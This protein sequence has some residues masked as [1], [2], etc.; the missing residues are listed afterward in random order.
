MEI[1]MDR[2]LAD[3]MRSHNKKDIVVFT[4]RCSS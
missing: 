1:L 3:Y 4:S 2:K